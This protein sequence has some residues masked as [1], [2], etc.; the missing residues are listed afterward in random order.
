[1]FKKNPKNWQ[2]PETPYEEHVSNVDTVLEVTLCELEELTS[3]ADEN[4]QIKKSHWNVIIC[5]TQTLTPIH[6]QLTRCHWI[7]TKIPGRVPG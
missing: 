4:F 1:M 6:L 5:L 2:F 3:S 7:P